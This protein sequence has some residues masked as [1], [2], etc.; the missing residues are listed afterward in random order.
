MSLLPGVPSFVT[1]EGLPF[2]LQVRLDEY[3]KR[4][5]MLF[6]DIIDPGRAQTKCKTAGETQTATDPLLT[7]YVGFDVK[8]T[9]LHTVLASA[10]VNSMW[11]RGDPGTGK[12]ALVD[13]LIRARTE[14]RLSS[15]M[16]GAP[17]F[18]FNVSLFLTQ[19][20]T[21]W[22][23]DFNKALDIV[24][25]S[26]GLLIIDHIDDLVQASHEYSD[27]L[28]QSLIAALDAATTSSALSFPTRRTMT[29]FSTPQPVSCGASRSWRWTSPAST[30]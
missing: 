2:L 15:S 13:E 14:K 6:D 12:T 10:G 11:I 17:F 4:L 16:L 20:S 3:A 29:R 8:L 24:K 1:S 30:V 21:D 18:L 22:L 9:E 25:N 28:M 27:R 23:T 5:A 26:H 19:I 7:R